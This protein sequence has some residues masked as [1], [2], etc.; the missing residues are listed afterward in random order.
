MTGYRC[1]KE[2]LYLVHLIIDKVKPVERQGRKATG[3]RF[4]R[5]A[6]D[7]SPKDPKIAGLPK[8]ISTNY[9]TPNHEAR[10]SR[11]LRTPSRT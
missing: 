4:L 10:E 7:D 8:P 11:K 3:P 5:E 9:Q 2:L 1:A 6:T